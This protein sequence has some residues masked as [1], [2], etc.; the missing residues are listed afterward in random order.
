MSYQPLVKLFCSM[1]VFSQKSLNY[2]W[3]VTGSDFYQ[4]HELL[5][6]VYTTMDDFK[7]RLAEHIRG[8]GRAPGLFTAFLQ[9]SSVK[10]NMSIPGGAAMFSELLSDLQLLRAD[11]KVASDAATQA[12]RQ[13]TLNLLGDIDESFDTIYYLLSSSQLNFNV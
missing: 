11:L 8:Y 10:E 12:N 4:H 9:L 2:H 13:G 1:Q 6:R 3:N 7:D 5:G